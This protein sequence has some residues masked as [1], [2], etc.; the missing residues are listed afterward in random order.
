MKKY[1]KYGYKHLR[2]SLSATVVLSFFSVIA[3]IAS[4]V[5]AISTCTSDRQFQQYQKEIMLVENSEDYIKTAS[6]IKVYTYYLD[7]LV[8]KCLHIDCPNRVK[9]I[10]T[11]LGA[12]FASKFETNLY[13]SISKMEILTNESYDSLIQH[14]Y[15]YEATLCKL[16][17]AL[18]NHAIK[19][20]DDSINRTEELENYVK[21]YK[22]LHPEDTIKTAEEMYEYLLYL[23][24][25]D[26]DTVMSNYYYSYTTCRTNIQ[27]VET[28]YKYMSKDQELIR[29]LSEYLYALNTLHFGLGTTPKTNIDYEKQ[30]GKF[31][32]VYYSP[33]TNII[34]SLFENQ[35]R[36]KISK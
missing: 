26:R 17:M 5:A 10:D 31:D 15:N 30:R 21:V 16:A 18:E 8:Y 14:L 25:D 9:K 28:L 7:G 1:L 4:S 23:T 35:G 29:R 19:Y 36:Y 12:S 11:L 24:T 2:K 32:N 33:L 34:D 22:I 27:G 13:S 3:A 6:E 20:F